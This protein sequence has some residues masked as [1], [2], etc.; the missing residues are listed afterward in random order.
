[1]KMNKEDAS[2]PELFMFSHCIS[3][4][5][6]F[7][8]QSTFPQARKSGVVK[9]LPPTPARGGELPDD[10]SSVPRRYVLCHLVWLFKT[11]TL[12]QRRISRK[13]RC[14]FFWI[15]SSSFSLESNI[16]LSFITLSVWMNDQ[17]V[18]CV[19]PLQRAHV[20]VCSVS[21]LDS[22]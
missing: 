13:S 3:H 14:L 9:L 22:V 15:L 5:Y 4:L 17:P 10:A 20:L 2:L 21:S 6:F 19:L 18:R 7:S 12:V 1:M 8:F 16:F 11:F